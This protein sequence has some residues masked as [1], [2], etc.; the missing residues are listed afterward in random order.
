MQVTTITHFL[1]AIL[2]LFTIDIIITKIILMKEKAVHNFFFFV[3]TCYLSC[4]I[5]F[6]PGVKNNSTWIYHSYITKNV[7]LK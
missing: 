4:T 7:K 1:L 2:Y 3:I 5:L 6:F